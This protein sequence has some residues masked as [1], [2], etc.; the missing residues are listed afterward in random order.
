MRLLDVSFR[1]QVYIPVS[2]GVTLMIVSELSKLQFELMYWSDIL[3][4]HLLSE[5]F[6]VT[7]VRGWYPCTVQTSVTF[8]P[9]NLGTIRDG[10]MFISDEFRVAQWSSL[11]TLNVCTTCPQ[12]CSLY[13][14]NVV[15]LFGSSRYTVRLALYKKCVLLFFTLNC[16]SY[17]LLGL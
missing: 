15:S 2:S 17:T 3:L 10:V 13:L 16:P 4:T 6:Q 9:A 11:D 7:N 12:T 8:S 1:L 14:P 5:Q